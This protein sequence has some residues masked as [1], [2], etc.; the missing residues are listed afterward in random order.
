VKVLKSGHRYA[1][2]NLKGEGST[3][4][5]FYQDPDLHDGERVEGPSTQEVIRAVIERVQELD[6]EKPWEGN[7][8]IIQKAREMLVLFEVRALLR[9][10]EKGELA[11]ESLPMGADGHIIIQGSQQ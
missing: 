7:S 10:V 6:R 2:Q 3:I 9:K 1:L 8:A 4:L 11:I 5:Q